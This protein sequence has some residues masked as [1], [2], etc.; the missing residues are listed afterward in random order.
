MTPE[1]LDPTAIGGA[2]SILGTMIVVI[3]LAFNRLDKQDSAW[4]EIINAAERRAENAEKT[5]AELRKFVHD[6]SISVEKASRENQDK[7][8]ELGE[9]LREA[10]LQIQKLQSQDGEK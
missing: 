3:R 10:K 2:L 5:L 1:G 8:D 9:Q 7:I 6:A 4:V